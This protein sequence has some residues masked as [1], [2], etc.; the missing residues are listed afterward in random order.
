MASAAA[1]LLIRVRNEM[2][3][4]ATD[5]VDEEEIV[6]YFIRIGASTLE[7]SEQMFHR[8]HTLQIRFGIFLKMFF[9]QEQYN[10][11]IQH[12]DYFVIM[13]D[14]LEITQNSLWFQ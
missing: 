9:Q 8:I 5:D 4:S 14:H 13:R 10:Y 11:W 1:H 12:C 2:S 3:L 6:G 7:E